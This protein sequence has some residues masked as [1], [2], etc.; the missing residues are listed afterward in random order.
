MRQYNRKHDTI[1]WYTKSSDHWV[2]NDHLIRENH[3]EKTKGNFKSGLQGSGFIADTYSL[4]EKGKIP[5]D[6]WIIAVAG[7]YPV[8]GKK[9]VGYAT[10]KPWP[11][12]ERIIK[13]SSR[14]G[15]I[16]ADFFCGS[17]TAL[18]VAERLGRRWIG[19]DLGK[20]ACMITR[21]RL[22]DQ[23]A[24]PFL[25]QHI[26]DYQLETARSMTGRRVKTG[27]LAQIILGLYGALA[28]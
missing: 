26:G 9:R 6:W 5:E 10:E 11:L 19:V 4:E 20:P 7:R 14:E 25:Y 27:D 28:A 21:K 17:G 16:I 13:A 15:S 8:D 3:N 23:E 18:A 22:I 2:F 1:F 12:L 24:A